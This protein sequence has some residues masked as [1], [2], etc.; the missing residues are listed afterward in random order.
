[1]Y[2]HTA[3]VAQCT[4]DVTDRNRLAD[5]L[6]KRFAAE[7]TVVNHYAKWLWEEMFGLKLPD[8]SYTSR[9]GSKLH[10]ELEDRFADIRN[11]V[12]LCGEQR[13]REVLEDQ[14]AWG[15]DLLDRLLDGQHCYKVRDLENEVAQN[16]NFIIRND[17]ILGNPRIRDQ[18]SDLTDLLKQDKYYESEDLIFYRNRFVKFCK[19]L[20]VESCVYYFSLEG[21][22]AELSN[23]YAWSKAVDLIDRSGVEKIDFVDLYS[24]SAYRKTYS[25]NAQFC[26]F[27]SLKQYHSYEKRLEPHIVSFGSASLRHLWCQ[28]YDASIGIRLADSSQGIVRRI[29]NGCLHNDIYFLEVQFGDRIETLYS[30]QTDIEFMIDGQYCSNSD[31][32]AFGLY[33]GNLL[34]DKGCKILRDRNASS[35]SDSSL[36][37]GD[38]GAIDAQQSV[39]QT[40]ADKSVEESVKESDE[41]DELYGARSVYDYNHYNYRLPD[42]ANINPSDRL[43]YLPIVNPSM[44]C[45]LSVGSTITL[46]KRGSDGKNRYWGSCKVLAPLTTYGALSLSK[47]RYAHD[48]YYKLLPVGH[49]CRFYADSIDTNLLSYS[50]MEFNAIPFVE[51]KIYNSY[52]DITQHIAKF[53]TPFWHIWEYQSQ[54][55]QEAYRHLYV[56]LCREELVVDYRNYLTLTSRIAHCDLCGESN[57]QF[58]PFDYRF[59][60]LHDTQADIM[61]PLYKNKVNRNRFVVLCPTCHARLHRAMVNGCRC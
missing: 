16:Y 49:F 23:L 17:L 22:L 12:E 29:N 53:Y 9:C 48:K 6:T 2:E 27:D 52:L 11:L 37:V 54:E 61:H 42:N 19:L 56:H 35:S 36:S 51:R 47:R 57:A 24:G 38:T 40:V 46:W 33:I 31:G 45:G 26:F 60:E 43:Y 7:V 30:D 14:C 5:E 21:K 3:Y 8:V 44:C 15:V 13:V 50:I 28:R 59:F 4:L 25:D 20:G 1:M 39:P 41:D 58:K 10:L 55:E 34:T 18:W 32:R